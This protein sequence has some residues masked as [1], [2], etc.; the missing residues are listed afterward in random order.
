MKRVFFHSR[1][2]YA[3]SAVF[4]LLIVLLKLLTAGKFS[5]LQTYSDGFFIAGLL[6]ICGGGLS[7][8]NYF[9]GF[10]IFSC[11]FAKRDAEGH[12][13]TL[14]EFSEMKAEKRKSNPFVFIPYFTVGIFSLIVASV[15]LIFC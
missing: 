15:L 2:R 7:V 6:L 9:G 10:D 11:M 3:I 13:P 12:K 8:V 1:T 4:A 5:S 14:Q